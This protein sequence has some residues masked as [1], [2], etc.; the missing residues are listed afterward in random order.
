MADFELLKG[1]AGE[2]RYL[3]VR[4]PLNE[5]QFR[6]VVSA[7]DMVVGNNNFHMAQVGS[8]TEFGW[9]G[10]F[11]LAHDE[12]D[13]KVSATVE[14]LGRLGYSAVLAD[15][16]TIFLDGPEDIFTQFEKQYATR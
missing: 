8:T 5:D 1:R 15:G 12:L 10:P 14:T 2:T 4:P 11:A 3:A 13:K 9:D 7:L 6:R 16:E